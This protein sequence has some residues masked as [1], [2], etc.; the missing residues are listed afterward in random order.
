MPGSTVEDEFI[1]VHSAAVSWHS[2]GR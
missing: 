1:H 2:M